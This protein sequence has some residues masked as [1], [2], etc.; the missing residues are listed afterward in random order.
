LA[1]L[2]RF[3]SRLSIRLLAFNVLLVFL[4]AA[5]LLYL[6]T[7]EKQL[8][9]AQEDAMVQQARLL[10]AALSGPYG[11]IDQWAA[12]RT[13][14]QLRRRHQARLRVVDREGF[15][16]ADS[17]RIGPKR[18]PESADETYTSYN[19]QNSWLYRLGAVPFRLY[20]K[21]VK[22][23]QPPLESGDYYSEKERLLGQ[24]VLAALAGRYGAATRISGGQ[25]SV[26]L[27]TA[28]PIRSRKEIVGAALVSQST[29]GILQILYAVRLDILRVFLVS[30]AVAAVLSLLVSTTIA[31]PLR[32]LRADA[33]AIADRRGRLK[34]SFGGTNRRDEIG[35]LSRALQ[36]V[37][38]RLR[39]HIDFIEAFAS[40]VSH[41]FKNPLASIRA[42]TDVL[43]EVSDP[44]DRRRFAKMT[45][46]EVARMERLLS[47]VREIT[48]ID[49]QLED[50]PREVVN[51]A[52]LVEQLVAGYRLRSPDGVRFD[53]TANGAG[54]FVYAAPDRIAQVV[55]NVLDNAVSFSPSDGQV[56]IEVTQDGQWIE[57]SI[58]DDGPGVAAENRDRMFDRFFTYRPE[59]AE[60]NQHM[61]L[62]L[63][64]AKAIV[65]SYGGRVELRE[66]DR[67]ARFTIRLP[68]HS[69]KE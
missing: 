3:F 41:E 67:G 47:G 69:M 55:Q 36:E 43:A 1:R 20:R 61:G 44:N 23:P 65:E 18:E 5:G 31:R 4:P 39:K 53:V 33:L 19:P 68:L 15:L 46:N 66:G 16:I 35:D 57:T 25:R 17:S 22:A 26:T 58:E 38:T 32:R 29:Y 54:A 64:I 50:E 28:V 8:L 27:Y 40:D 56:G 34:G 6:N 49:A 42:A 2:L 14:Q 37:T 10:A 59:G 21:L 11:I 51:I 24:E 9:V 7:Y 30:V 13:L 48:Q 60:L 62:G 63:P 12:E 45:R 52:V